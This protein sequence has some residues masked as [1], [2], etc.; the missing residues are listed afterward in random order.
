MKKTNFNFN[1][2]HQVECVKRTLKRKTKLFTNAS[3]F[4]E[5][6]STAECFRSCLKFFNTSTGDLFFYISKKKKK[7]QINFA[8]PSFHVSNSILKFKHHALNITEVV[9]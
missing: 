7:T 1:I 2:R 8:T 4:I 5:T 9:N 3:F 6:R